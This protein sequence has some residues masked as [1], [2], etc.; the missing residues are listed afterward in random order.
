MY[1]FQ[2]QSAG[3]FWLSVIRVFNSNPLFDTQAGIIVK[4]S[5]LLGRD[6][7]CLQFVQTL[8]L[9]DLCSRATEAVSYT[10]LDVYKRQVR[11]GY[12]KGITWKIKIKKVIIN[13]QFLN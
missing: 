2:I 4:T 12:V 13:L 10:H 3:L 11:G 5:G 1:V 8:D 7:R 9:R 6:P